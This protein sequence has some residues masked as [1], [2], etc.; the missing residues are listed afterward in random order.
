MLALLVSE[1]IEK[2]LVVVPTDALREQ[3]A[4]KFAT[5][6]ELKRVTCL[7][8]DAL[9]PLTAVLKRGPKTVEEIDALV[10]RAQVIVATMQA[11]AKMLP[12]LQAQLADAISHLFIDEAHHIGAKTWKSLKRRFV[13]KK[14]PIL[15]FTATPYRNDER[16]ID[17]KFIFTYPLR[18]AQEQDLFRPVHY[19]PVMESRQDRADL[20]IIAKVGAALDRDLANNFDHLAMARTDGIERAEHLLALYIKH[21]PKHPAALVHSK[22]RAS[23][24]AARL[25]DLRHGRI[26][27]IVCVDMLGEGFDLPKLKIA[28][29]HDPHKSEAITFQFIG[30]FTRRQKG[31]GDATV[32]ARVSLNDPHELLNALYREDADWNHLLRFGSAL[33]IER[34]KRREDLYG[35]LDDIFEGIPFDAVAPRLS[36]FVFPNELPAMAASESG[37]SGTTVRPSRR[38]A[39]RQRRICLRNDGDAPRRSAPMGEGEPAHRRDL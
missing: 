18:R 39:Y 31:L 19:E 27:I 30:R 14:K 3:I 25:E 38:G 10:G 26:R 29:L 4:T 24:R 32:I 15:Q 16:R 33:S 17:G 11:L 21:L 1:P 20:A 8:E 28:G 7:R 13:E 23:E 22:M 6:G 35:G 5:L 12:E 34:E 36:A 37:R 2:L 9:Y